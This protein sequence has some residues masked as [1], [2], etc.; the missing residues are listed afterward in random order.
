MNVKVPHWITKL[1]DEELQLF[2]WFCDRTARLH[3]YEYYYT[4]HIEDVVKILNKRNNG[5]LD[6]VLTHDKFTEWIQLGHIYDTVMTFKVKKAVVE[7]EV[8]P[9]RPRGEKQFNI[10]LTR[11]RTQMMYMYLLGCLNT[12]MIEEDSHNIQPWK[13]NAFGIY[14]FNLDRT[15][16]GYIKK[17]DR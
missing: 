6:W 17:A 15:A 14:E 13:L 3:G 2:A 4:I 10:E 9:G 5:L 12:N 1:E 8:R 7:K 11:Y 16:I